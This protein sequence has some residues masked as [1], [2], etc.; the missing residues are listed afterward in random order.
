VGPLGVVSWIVSPGVCP[1]LFIPWSVSTGGAP[2][3]DVS[4]KRF[5]EGS[6]VGFPLEW[7]SLRGPLRI[8]W[9]DLQE[10]IH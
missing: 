1:L 3:Q 2:V 6:T 4:W 5:T 7:V 8:P 10:I 9:G